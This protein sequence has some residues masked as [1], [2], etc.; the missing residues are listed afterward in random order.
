MMI[1]SLRGHV[2]PTKLLT[3]CFARSTRPGSPVIIMAVTIGSDT[4]FAPVRN[5]YHGKNSIPPLELFYETIV[6]ILYYWMSRN[7]TISKSQQHRNCSFSLLRQA[8]AVLLRNLHPREEPQNSTSPGYKAIFVFSVSKPIVGI[9]RLCYQT[10][11]LFKEL[12]ESL[13][14]CP[15]YGGG[16]GERRVSV[17]MIRS[18]IIQF[19]IR[20]G[21]VA[22]NVKTVKRRIASLARHDVRL[23]VL[24]E[25]WSTGFANKRLKELSDTTPNVLEDLSSVAKRLRLTI[26]GSMPENVRGKVYNTAY[27]ID[28]DGSVA[29]TYRKVHLFSL[30]G[31]HR[32]FKA[33]RKAVISKT[34]LGPIGLM[35]CYDL[36][37][38]ELC[39]ALALDGAKMVVVMAQWPAARVAHWD[40][41]LKARAV[42]NQLFVFGANRCGSDPD[43]MYAGHSR[44]IS[45]YGEVM[46][47]A[48]RQSA[49]L[50]ATIDLRAVQQTRKHIPCLKQRVPEAY[51]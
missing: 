35:I 25:M 20:R 51:G 5:A 23:V 21:D 29:G 34:S 7:M 28:R 10:I 9:D 30:T 37:F 42:E 32:H 12:R 31:E 33:G 44:I 6:A 27:V 16:Y 38:P 39:R 46:A 8:T 1:S 45:P 41:L 11:S 49:T 17:K 50:S 18:V 4:T 14:G 13:L 22:S 47:R 24:P 43:I 19:D 26:I 36:R 3:A 2:W 40:V 15:Y 48:G